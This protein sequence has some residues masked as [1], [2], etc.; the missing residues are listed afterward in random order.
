L[1][2]KIPR[3]NSA[4]FKTLTAR[5]YSVFV[6]NESFIRGAAYNDGLYIQFWTGEGYDYACGDPGGKEDYYG[7]MLGQSS[8]MELQHSGSALQKLSPSECI[9][10]Y[11]TDFLTDRGSL[12]AITNAT[13]FESRQT[14][15]SV[16][17]WTQSNVST[18]TTDVGGASD[19]LAWICADIE[20]YT[21]GTYP[22]SLSLAQTIASDWTIFGYP[23]DYCLSKPND[24]LCTLQF[25]LVIMIVVIL[26][27]AV[28]A[29]AMA[30]TVI[31]FGQDSPLVTVGYASFLLVKIRF[32][33]TGN[34][35]LL[36]LLRDAAASYLEQPDPTTKGFCLFDQR[37]PS[38]PNVPS[39][40]CDPRELTW[41]T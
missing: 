31:S 16:Y 4:I 25:S 5:R 20:S 35:H 37:G 33:D 34:I 36:T 23:I 38:C 11:T 28:K 22:C 9:A 1:S 3:Y 21:N 12:L 13:Y 7:L 29:T 24:G 41:P 2:S 19:P 14:N 39:N 18:S 17:G 30:L 27:N 26:A 40:L 6:V 15:G 8:V 10:A 32:R